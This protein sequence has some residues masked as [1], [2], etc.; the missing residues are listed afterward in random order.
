MCKAY[1]KRENKRKN[2]Y[3]VPWKQK[4]KACTHKSIDDTAVIS[5]LKLYV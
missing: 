5:C 2:V 1:S 3:K 4:H